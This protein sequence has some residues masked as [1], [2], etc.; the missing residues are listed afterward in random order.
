M[1]DAYSTEEESEEEEEEEEQNQ[2]PIMTSAG[3]RRESN[4]GGVA[5]GSP[6]KSFQGTESPQKRESIHSFTSPGSK[7]DSISKS[8]AALDPKRSFTSIPNN[9][10]T[11]TPQVFA[12]EFATLPSS[13]SPRHDSKAVPEPRRSSALNS[14]HRDIKEDI[15]ALIGRR[16]SIAALSSSQ[17]LDLPHVITAEP[18]LSP[19]IRST[20]QKEVKKESPML[21]TSNTPK[22]PSDFSASHNS[23]VSSKQ[24]DEPSP[25]LSGNALTLSAGLHK[26][27]SRKSSFDVGTSEPSQAAVKPS[28]KPSAA[29]LS[30][31]NLD[32][33]GLPLDPRPGNNTKGDPP[34]LEAALKEGSVTGSSRRGSEQS[35]QSKHSSFSGK[36]SVVRS[37]G[38]PGSRRDSVVSQRH[39]SGKRLSGMWGDKRPSQ[40]LIHRNS[41]VEMVHQQQQKQQ[42][43]QKVQ[44][45]ENS[46]EETTASSENNS[47]VPDEMESSSSSESYKN[48]KP[49]NSP[50][51]TYAKKPYQVD[52]PSTVQSQVSTPASL[53]RERQPTAP[54][55][56]D[57]DAGL[58]QQLQA[59]SSTATDSL[60]ESGSQI[61][62]LPASGTDSRQPAD[63][64]LYDIKRLQN[65]AMLIRKD[66][67]HEEE[68]PNQLAVAAMFEFLKIDINSPHVLFAGSAQRWSSSNKSEQKL[69]RLVLVT[70]S[71]IYTWTDLGTLQ[72]CIPIQGIDKILMSEDGWVGIGVPLE[73]DMLLHF[74]SKDPD[75]FAKAIASSD[76]GSLFVDSKKHV[77]SILSELSLGRPKGW[78]L[79]PDSVVPIV[80]TRTSDEN[81]VVSRS[82]PARSPQE[83]AQFIDIG[84]L[85]W[86]PSV[87]AI[88]LVTSNA[89][90]AAFGTSG[91]PSE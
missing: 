46:S 41:I 34:F 24:E 84:R 15:D 25:K 68:D 35:Q 65:E 44:K 7:R 50:Q 62:Y 38:Q 48:N 27:D 21:N 39:N 82:V 11:I 18:P 74:T 47:P 53:M 49:T 86:Q 70:K 5:F 56:I 78:V 73:F 72:R 71:A 60:P 29:I 69:H 58:V 32:E 67:H 55:G 63:D 14:S 22:S 37:S 16:A 87:G 57:L 28:K 3:N 19:D 66:A 33:N 30:L 20:P 54:I 43:Q 75:S 64:L 80:P 88:P 26:S 52:M 17:R 42:Q 36:P 89:P 10:S 51:P 31:L 85:L 81:N 77:S 91:V 90:I 40:D 13:R 9:E 2:Q 79:N 4:F 1:P 83:K 23:K 12:P 76:S 59:H 8:F 6:S 61:S 45:Q